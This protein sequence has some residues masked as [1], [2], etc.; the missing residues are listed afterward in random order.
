MSTI[1]AAAVDL[2]M[3]KAKPASVQV[4]EAQNLKE[5]LNFALKVCE[6]K[7]LAT[8]APIGEVS[9]P[10]EGRKKTFAA[11][12]LDD[13]AWGYLLEAGA[14][15]DFKMIRQGLRNY[16]HGID[17]AFSLADFG[18]ADTASSVIECENEDERLASMICESHVIALAKSKIFAQ[19]YEA[20]GLLNAAL[21]KERNF[22]AFISGPSRTAD[23]ERVLTLGVH[24][25]LE[26]YLVLVEE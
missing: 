7:P 15:M 24:G 26:L 22:T 19:S 1:N 3:A 2:F 17:V 12:A 4:S 23:I 9:P 5:A 14:K 20:E 10:A 6:R 16:L 18:L 13:K 21:A 8:L 11:P 25:P